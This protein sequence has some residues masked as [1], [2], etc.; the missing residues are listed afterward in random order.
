[1][2]GPG[3]P[4]HAPVL[5]NWKRLTE[6]D[7]DH[8][9][10]RARSVALLH[11][12]RTRSSVV[13]LHGFTNSPGQWLE[14]GR[15]LHEEGRSVFIPR[16][17]HHGHRNRLT[18]AIGRLT[19]ADLLV[20]GQAAVEAAAEAGERVTVVGLSLGGL[21]AAWLAQRRPEVE[22]TVLVAPLFAPHGLPAPLLTPL[23]LLA[24]SAPNAW[25]WWD[26]GVRADL[27]P[28]YGYPR[29]STRAFGQMLELGH[30]VAVDARRRP[31]TKS[32]VAVLTNDADDAVDN[33]ATA[34]LVGL[35]KARGVSVITH[36]FAR[37]E[38]LPHDLVDPGNPKAHTE[39]V[40][41]V[42]F[43]LIRRAE[44]LRQEAAGTGA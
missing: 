15:R 41:P 44:A 25:P 35:W 18:T 28:A 37:A 32:A 27:P 2:A 24:R 39:L 36:R 21:L 5:E 16:Y 7:G 10:P 14:A 43:D 13:L 4:Y 11:G 19:V 17:P 38:G 40:Y 1:M 23:R 31:P 42:L 33:R 26:S 3:S 34:G 30:R 20:T 6:S 22:A 9:H 8:I 12:Q 29:F